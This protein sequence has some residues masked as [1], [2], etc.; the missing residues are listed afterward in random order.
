MITYI[1]YQTYSS[2]PDGAYSTTVKISKQKS[3]Q[4]LTKISTNNYS[5]S[6]AFFIYYCATITTTK[7]LSNHQL[8][9]FQESLTLP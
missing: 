9:T 1:I 3:K 7:L 4:T 5:F 8:E 6:F 2:W